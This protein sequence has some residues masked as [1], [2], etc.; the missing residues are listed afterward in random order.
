MEQEKLIE[1][2]NKDFPGYSQQ[3][4]QYSTELFEK[5]AK[6]SKVDVGQNQITCN[7]YYKAKTQQDKYKKSISSSRVLLIVRCVLCILV[8]V[9]S[10]LAALIFEGAGRIISIVLIVVSL[11][12]LIGYPIYYNKKKKNDDSLLGKFTEIADKYQEE[13]SE[14]RRPLWNRIYPNRADELIR[15]V[16]P[17]IHI[18]L[19]FD[20]NRYAYRVKKFGLPRSEGD[21]EAS[22]IFSKSGRINGNPFL[23][24]REKY[25][26]DERKTYVGTRTVM[27]RRSYRDSK[28][29]TH[30]TSSPEVLTAYHSEIA[31]FY[32]FSQVLIF[33]SEAAPDLTFSRQPVLKK[34]DLSNIKKII[35]RNDKL[36]EKESIKQRN[37]NDPTTNLQKRSNEEFDSLFFARD[38]NNEVQFRLRFT[39]LAQINRVDLIKNSPYGDD[40]CFFKSKRLNYILTNHSLDYSVDFDCGGQYIFDFKVRRDRFIQTRSDYFKSFYYQLAPLLC[41]PLYQQHKPFEYIYGREYGFSVSPYDHEAMSNRVPASFLRPKGASTDRILKSKYIRSVADFDLISV[42]S[43]SYHANPQTILIPKTASDGNVYNVSVSYYTYSRVSKVTE[44]AVR[45]TSLVNK[46]LG[47]KIAEDEIHQLISSI[48]TPGTLIYNNDEIIFG[49]KSGNQG[50]D[51]ALKKLSDA[52]KKGEN[53]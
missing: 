46:E 47:V 19:N 14:Q 11:G 23:I 36:L 34:D 32:D 30:Y 37:D 1:N 20:I 33:G 43:V 52:L 40:F 24:L 8:V 53:K 17:L 15:K 4:T 28:G 6:E 12:V 45:K 50:L 5:L 29:H 41:V 39:P 3:L 13:A 25:H 38:R 9:I 18:D 7:E 2:P 31:P 44:F 21:K 26:H 49:V 42:E 51:N 48:D 10:F 35:K 22:V 16:I 27:V